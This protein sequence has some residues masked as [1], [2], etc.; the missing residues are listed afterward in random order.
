MFTAL[1]PSMLR[2]SLGMMQMAS[3][4]LLAIGGA[5]VIRTVA[6][7][8]RPS[9]T[10]SLIPLLQREQGGASQEPA[11]LPKRLRIPRIGVDTGVEEVGL[12]ETGGMDTPRDPKHVGWFALG[13]RPGDAGNAV[14][15][16]H[17]NT[18]FGRR[19]VFAS[20]S[21]LRQGDEVYVEND[22]GTTEHFRVNTLQSYRQQEAPLL[23]IF[24]SDGRARLN[25]IT[26]NG[27]WDWSQSTYDERLVVFTELVK[28]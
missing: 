10:S 18:A 17:L 20:L 12:T 4:L 8:A 1:S 7:V 14:I 23:R 16:G 21:S 13:S 25:L 3:V 11:A 15:V 5:L 2:R 27:R 22:R 26:C 28:D 9:A 24:G 19:A 6:A